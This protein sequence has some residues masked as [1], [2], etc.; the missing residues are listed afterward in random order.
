MQ[1]GR[2]RKQGPLPLRLNL[3][4]IMQHGEQDLTTDGELGTNIRLLNPSYDLL[5][6]W[7]YFHWIHSGFPHSVFT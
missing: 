1:S 7:V 2:I 4:N 3:T 5:I 6:F